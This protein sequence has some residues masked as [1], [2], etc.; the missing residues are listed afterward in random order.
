MAQITYRE[1][2]RAALREEL[3]RDERVLIIGAEV[4]FF[5]GAFK[6]SEGLLADFGERRVRDMPNSPHTIV[7]AGIGA[8]LGGLRPIVELLATDADAFVI[9]RAID[10]MIRAAAESKLDGSLKTK[11][12]IVIRIVQL[13]DDRTGLRYEQS[14]AGFLVG[15]E[16][17]QIAAPVTPAD[18]KGLLK[19]AIRS[20]RPVIFIEHESL[21]DI[22]GEVP[23]DPDFL[24]PFGQAAVEIA[25]RSI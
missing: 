20:D 21:Y 1:A 16:S 25:R 3:E 22:R 13:A 2:L 4:G 14:V 12:P 11:I 24:L 7:G 6:V 10:R 8:A 5:G 17:I 23:D 18:A 15:S 19:S 9:E